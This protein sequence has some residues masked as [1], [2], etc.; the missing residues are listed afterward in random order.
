MKHIY[1]CWLEQISADDDDDV[2]DK[3]VFYKIYGKVFSFFVRII[4]IFDTNDLF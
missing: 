3:S 2:I 1:S 4:Y